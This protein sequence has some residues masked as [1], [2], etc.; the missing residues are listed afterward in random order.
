MTLSQFIIAGVVVMNMRE[1]LGGAF[2]R[3]LR[4][5]W[6]ANLL[7]DQRLGGQVIAAGGVVAML[8]VLAVLIARRRRSTAIEQRTAAPSLG[9]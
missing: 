4:L 1:V 9:S 3:S 2:Y 7:G 8:A 6:H 5:S